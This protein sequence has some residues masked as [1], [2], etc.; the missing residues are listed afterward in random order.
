L[1]YKQ[2][3]TFTYKQTGL[4]TRVLVPPRKGASKKEPHESMWAKII[5]INRDG[6]QAIA[7]LQNQPLSGEYSW[8]DLVLI[9]KEVSKNLPYVKRKVSGVPDTEDWGIL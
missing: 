9:K 7:I 2:R 6:K 5:A 1:S 8:G 4:S 3:Q